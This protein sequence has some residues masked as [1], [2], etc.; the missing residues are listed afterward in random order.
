MS[1]LFQPLIVRTTLLP[2][3]YLLSLITRLTYLNFYNNLHFLE[4][5][6]LDPSHS[7][8]SDLSKEHLEFPLKTEVYNILSSLTLI[9]PL[10]IYRSTYHRFALI[11][12]LPSE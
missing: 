7:H 11:F 4:K 5:L 6:I 2:D 3:E 12:I 9:D 10:K 8:C 1:K